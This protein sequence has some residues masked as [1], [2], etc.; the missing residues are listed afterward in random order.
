[1]V[2][3]KEKF[4]LGWFGDNGLGERIIQMILDGRKTAT[5]CPIYDPYDAESKVG[6]RL[7]LLDKHG[8]KYGVVEILRI[9]TRRFCDFDAPLIAAEG[10]SV[11]ELR[12][13]MK[14]ANAHDIR[15]EEEM[16][17]VHFRLVEKAPPRLR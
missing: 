4:Q 12:D 9:E 5:A 13:L 16:R 6:D 10:M 2:G 3:S 14:L 15:P 7:D 17:V 11:A 1:M 8:R